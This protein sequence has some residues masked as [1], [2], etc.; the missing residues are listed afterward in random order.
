M[1]IECDT[2]RPH[3]QERERERELRPPTAAVQSRRLIVS[4]VMLNLTRGT[5]CLAGHYSIIEQLQVRLGEIL[6][7]NDPDEARGTIREIGDER[8]SCA[9]RGGL[10]LLRIASLAARIFSSFRVLANV[11]FS[12]RVEIS[13]HSRVF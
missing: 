5:N 9:R 3:A 1:G 10:P 12:R 4:A 8:F 6:L 11:Y 7:A 13:M 2:A